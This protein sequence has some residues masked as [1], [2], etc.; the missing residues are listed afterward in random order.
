M[1]TNPTRDSWDARR[2]RRAKGICRDCPK[3]AFGKLLCPSCSKKACALN[4]ARKKSYVEKGLCGQCGSKDTGAKGLCQPCR[5]GVFSAGMEVTRDELMKK[6]VDQEFK[7]V[8][9]GEKLVLGE[10]ASVDHILPVTRGG[11]SIIEN[12]QWTT[13][14]VNRMKFTMNHQEF[15]AACRKVVDHG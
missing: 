13:K 8:Y 9:T 4:S 14:L 11:T 12:L 5:V 2:L 10:N 1:A 3:P 6:L 7:C 15:I